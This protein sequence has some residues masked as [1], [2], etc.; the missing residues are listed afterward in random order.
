[1]TAFQALFYLLAVGALAGGVGTVWSKNVVHSALFLVLSLLAVAGFYLLL[2]ADFL[3]L[4]QVMLYG[5]AVTILLLF[6]LMLTRGRDE[7]L[8]LDNSQKPWAL[9]A[10]LLFLGILSFVAYRTSWA[11][12]S[13][14][15]LQRVEISQLGRELFLQW[16]VPFEVASLVLLVAL[17]GAI[18][19]ARGEERE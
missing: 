9:G 14:T 7:P 2:Y 16:A 10:G 11:G 13:A 5:G 6:A 4:V 15:P 1:M 19:I 17:M 18:I 8:T 3:A 12:P